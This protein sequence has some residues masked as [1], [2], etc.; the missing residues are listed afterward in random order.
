ME[1][2]PWSDPLHVNFRLEKWG[3]CTRLSCNL[4][5]LPLT[6]ARE[7]SIPQV[8][9]EQKRAFDWTQFPWYLRVCML[10][11]RCSSHFQMFPLRNC[12]A[13]QTWKEPHLKRAFEPFGA[14]NGWRTPW[15]EVPNVQFQGKK[16]RFLVKFNDSRKITF[17]F[18]VSRQT[19]HSQA[20]N[21]DLMW[22]GGGGGVLT[23]PKW[24]KLPLCIF[25]FYSSKL[26]TSEFVI[27]FLK[28]FL[29]FSLIFK[30]F[31][32]FF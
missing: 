7:L 5:L 15:R 28:F 1:T 3:K 6:A 30:I 13:F 11:R 22:G 27:L 24:T 14:L 26:E 18:H 20:R 32:K 23:R 2:A 21:Q 31:S 10:S 12:L 19:Y 16:C 9:C 4:G 8:S 25:W 29:N 17:C